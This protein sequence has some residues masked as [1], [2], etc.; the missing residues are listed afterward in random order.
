MMRADIIESIG[1]GSLIQH[2]SSND[3]IYLMSLDDRDAVEIISLLDGIALKG[4]YG[5]VFAKIP[6]RHRDLFERGGYVCEAEIPAFYL[7]GDAGSFM[8]RFL[9][10]ERAYDPHSADVRD[11]VEMALSKRSAA[12]CRP[13][14]EGYTL[15]VLGEGDAD[16]LAELYMEVFKSYPFPIH[17]PAYLVGTMRETIVYFGVELGDGDLVAASSSETD[18]KNLTAEMTDFAVRPRCRGAGLAIHLLRAMEDEMSARGVGSLYTIARAMSAGMNITFARCGY[19][20]A[21]TLVRNTN[22]SGR[23]ES[24]NVWYRVATRCP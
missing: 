2:G 19:T 6:G 13:M 21:G 4:G 5:K 11:I 14:E 20:Y 15:R 3:R 1:Q 23:I 9:S 18:M 8:G 16:S 10:A 12:V 22:I 17:D 7:D 24:M